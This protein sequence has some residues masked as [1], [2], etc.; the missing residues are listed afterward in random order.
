MK[1][2]SANRMDRKAAGLRG[3]PWLFR[4]LWHQQSLLCQK[5]SARCSLYLTDCIHMVL[6]FLPNAEKWYGCS[7]GTTTMKWSKAAC[8]FLTVLR[9]SCPAIRIWAVILASSGAIAVEKDGEPRWEAHR[10]CVAYGWSA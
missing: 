3:F 6:F 9:E 7:G 5:Q 10:F 4:G 2:A 1:F 8:A